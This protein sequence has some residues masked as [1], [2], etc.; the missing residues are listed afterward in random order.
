[1][2]K[3]QNGFGSSK[4]F[5]VKGPR[6][7]ED[8]ATKISRGRVWPKAA[9]SYPAD[10]RYGSSIQRTIIETYDLN[11]DWCRWRR[12]YEYYCQASEEE[13]IEYNKATQEYERSTI[14]SKLYQGT[15]YEIDVEFYGWRFPTQDSDPNNHYVIKRTVQS[16]VNLGKISVVYSDPLVDAEAKALHEVWTQINLGPDSRLLLRMVGERITDGET[17]ATMTY[18]LNGLKQPAIY[19]GKSDPERQMQVEV[20]VPL[21]QVLASDYVKANNND[22]RCL[23]NEIGY[24]KDFYVEKS[25]DLVDSIVFTDEPY[26]FYTTVYDAVPSQEFKILDKETD[27]PPSIYDIDNLK[28]IFQTNDADYEVRGTFV[29]Q[30]EIY[31]RF[32]GEKYLTAQVVEDAVTSVDYSVLPF[33]IND[34]IVRGDNVIFSTAPFLGSFNMY[35]PTLDPQGQPLGEGYLVFS[36][37]SFTRRSV[38]TYDG[39]YY[40][41]IPPPGSPDPFPIW[42]RIIN[43]I[44]PWKERVFAQQG[45]L[46]P[47]DM[48]SCSCPDYAS[49]IIRAP[50]TRDDEGQRKINRQYRY[51]LPTVMGKSAYGSI[52]LDSAAGVL[53][54]WENRTQRMSYKICKH[55]IAAM[56]LEHIKLQEPSQYPTIEARLEFEDKLRADIAETAGMFKESYERGGIS[57]VEVVFALAQGLNLSE[58]ETA[59]VVLNAKF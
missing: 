52:G 4:S 44:D 29:Y 10:R 22:P 32:F 19:M 55:S 13:L 58:I 16:E 14:E 33:V 48:F 38:D 23:V 8:I 49:A 47:E 30:K 57:T 46:K 31:Q 51:P 25:I 20:T 54:T 59:Y 12:G 5:A 40:H 9:G 36:D 37:Y 3:K 43:D 28:T 35:A 11:S 45:T 41:P 2:P 6:S 50:Q 17:A 26:Y 24:L 18:V 15:P 1:M 42:Y 39:E 53:Q 7:V 21:A 27:L 34:L 56:F